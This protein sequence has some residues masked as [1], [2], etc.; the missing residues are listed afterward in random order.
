MHLG[1]HYK[2]RVGMRR[3]TGFLLLLVDPRARYH[4][5]SHP[6]GEEYFVVEGVLNDLGKTWPHGSYP[7]HPAT[8]PIATRLR[9]R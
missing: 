3:T 1:V 4:A 5:H 2:T 6:G 7:W 9:K 8:G